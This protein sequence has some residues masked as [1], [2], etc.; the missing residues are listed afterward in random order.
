MWPDISSAVQDIARSASYESRGAATDLSH[1]R[2]G[3]LPKWRDERSECK[4]D[5]AQPVISGVQP[6]QNFAEFDHHPVRSKKEA[7]RYLVEVASTPPRRGGE[8][9]GN[10]AFRQQPRKPVV[11]AASMKI[12]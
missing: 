1:G 6:Q 4:R 3:L 9:C 12:S 5:S 2:K 7:S 8:N 11:V 10:S